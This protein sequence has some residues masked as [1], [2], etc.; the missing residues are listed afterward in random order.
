MEQKAF[1]SIPRYLVLCA[2][3]FVAILLTV[4]VLSA[5]LELFTWF[6]VG[7]ALWLTACYTHFALALED[8]VRLERKLLGWFWR[9]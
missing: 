1:A 4:W 6:Q 8:Q 2:C 3:S 7:M 9:F 5:V